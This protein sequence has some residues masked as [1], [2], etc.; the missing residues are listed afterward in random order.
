MN[1]AW[2]LGRRGVRAVLALSGVAIASAC[3]GENLFQ[4][5]V[6]GGGD[7]PTVNIT[8]PSEGS[9]LGAGSSVQVR[10]D[11]D[12]PNGLV[13][14]E[15]FGIFVADGTPAFVS[16]TESYS[17]PPFAAVSN[18]LSPQPGGAVGDVAII[19]RV[20]DGEGISASDTVKITVN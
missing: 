10:A 18:T 15:Y 8:A 12:A 5:P 7:D 17:R 16:E 6:T 14:A 20:T 19:L 2:L 9:T 4:G 11:V 13:S 3:A 1:A